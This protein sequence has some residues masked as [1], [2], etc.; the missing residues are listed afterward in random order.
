M[1]HKEQEQEQ[2][3]KYI[4]S[5]IDALTLCQQALQE[6]ADKTPK[7][8]M[9]NFKGICYGMATLLNIHIRHLNAIANYHEKDKQN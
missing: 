3:S 1:K 4:Y 7:H 9:P 5:L 6:L 8:T 2:E